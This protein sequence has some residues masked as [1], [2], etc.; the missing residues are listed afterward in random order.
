[1]RGDVEALATL[2]AGD[3]ESLGCALTVA[4]PAARQ[5]FWERLLRGPVEPAIHQVE[6]IGRLSTELWP[7]TGPR[8]D[9][10]WF[11]GVEDLAAT[12]GLDARLLRA[13][14]AWVPPCATRRLADRLLA[15]PA[16]ELFAESIDSATGEAFDDPDEFQADA[17]HAGVW[18]FLEVTAPAMFRTRLREGL[19]QPDPAVRGRC[20]VLL[21]KLGDQESAK[22]L[23]EWVKSEPPQLDNLYG[24][25]SL[26]AGCH[27]SEVRAHFAA[28][29]R[30]ED[31]S[32]VWDDDAVQALAV[33]LGMPFEIATEWHCEEEVQA[34]VLAALRAG[35]VAA[36]WLA[37]KPQCDYAGDI[38]RLLAWAD[39]RIQAFAQERLALARSAASDVGVFDLV[40][41]IGRRDPTAIATMRELIL[42]GRYV[43]H[44]T[45]RGQE[46]TLGRDLATLSFWIDEYG[47]NC[48]RRVVADEAVQSLLR[49]EPVNDHC[50]EPPSA[51][52]RRRLLSVQNRLRW[53]ALANGYVVAGN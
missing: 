23:L 47:T 3:P 37:S 36:A 32:G 45:F 31:G 19:A 44:N 6:T 34:E 35:D 48:C 39:P 1:M 9:D 28:R 2:F 50:N 7:L 15:Q 25:D 14:I 24:V 43:T 12:L 22:A 49:V 20:G 30:G 27:G 17:G 10:S 38:T 53:S 42:D 13:L 16:S 52:L 33:C 8:F 26:L 41:G 21:L 40:A 11:A 5:T 18:P 51:R 29:L 46:L 4:P